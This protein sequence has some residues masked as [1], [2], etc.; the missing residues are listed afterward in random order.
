MDMILVLFVI[1]QDYTLGYQ[2][3]SVTVNRN[4]AGYRHRGREEF[5]T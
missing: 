5:C 2:K 4:P 1:Y 3:L